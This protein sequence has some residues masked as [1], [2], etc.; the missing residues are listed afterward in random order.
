PKDT[1]Q[2][3]AN[4]SN[5]PNSLIKAIVSTN[6]IRKD[7]IIKSII[8]NDSKTIGVYRLLM[9]KNSDNFRNSI[10]L[11]IVNELKKYT[12]VII[13]EPLINDSVFNGCEVNNTLEDF[14][15]ISDLIVANRVDNHISK[16]VD[17]IFTTDI[18]KSDE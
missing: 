1:K 5:V 12:R 3:L 4:F 15:N 11:E 6:E 10:M 8:S 2:L 9:K 14:L 18:F 7:G 17:K 16:C 13:Y